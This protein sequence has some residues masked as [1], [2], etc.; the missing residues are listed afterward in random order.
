MKKEI[1]EALHSLS[2]KKYTTT[3]GRSWV[4]GVSR[5]IVT[6]CLVAA[7]TS[8]ILL[9]PAN[10]L[11]TTYVDENFDSYETGSINGQGNWTGTNPAISNISDIQSLSSSQSVN[12]SKTASQNASTLSFTFADMNTSDFVFSF[13]AYIGDTGSQNYYDSLM[14][15]RIGGD[16]TNDTRAVFVRSSTS[17]SSQLLVN[18]MSGS[19]YLDVP[20]EEWHNF[21][22]E[23]ICS[24]SGQRTSNFYYD[25]VLTFTRIRNDVSCPVYYQ[26]IISGDSVDYNPSGADLNFI[27]NI[28]LGSD[29]Q[30]QAPEN[31][32]TDNPWESGIYFTIPTNGTTT[33]TTSV[34]FEVQGYLPYSGVVTL[35]GTPYMLGAIPEEDYIIATTTA[36]A[37]ISIIN[38]DNLTC[39]SGSSYNFIA[40]WVSNSTTTANQVLTTPDIDVHCV[41]TS[42]YY[43][44]ITDDNDKG[45]FQN[46]F[47]QWY[48]KLQ[49]RFPF[50][51]FFL[52]QDKIG[53]MSQNATSSPDIILEMSDI[54]IAVGSPVTIPDITLF[55]WSWLSESE[56]GDLWDSW[57][58]LNLYAGYF[59]WLSLLFSILD[60]FLKATDTL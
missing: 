6:V 39:E 38:F 48:F 19:Y 25:N 4:V 31:P 36:F 21:A 52:F 18:L 50:A 7:T 47:N 1:Q 12:Q 54:S 32:L 11:A 29:F 59:I 3:R 42:T 43:T 41:S 53:E 27:D 46:K 8:G 35:T 30:Q 40:T 57:L 44:M 24:V 33:P 14:S 37:G 5:T 49:H 51:Y 28:Y 26:T 16:D 58:L 20:D 17:S 10:V 34:D 60:D 22:F 2:R 9:R 13:D 23:N 15:I 55:S 56:M 45:Y